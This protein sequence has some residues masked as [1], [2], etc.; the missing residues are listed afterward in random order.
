M[1]A[2]EDVTK[3]Q[4]GKKMDLADVECYTYGKKGH[5]ARACPDAVQV[6]REERK[7][8]TPQRERER[9]RSSMSPWPG[10]ES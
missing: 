2:E 9:A 3:H 4:E 8:D 1:N 6:R 10:K 7:W 5:M